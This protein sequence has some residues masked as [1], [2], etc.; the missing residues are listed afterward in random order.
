MYPFAD[1]TILYGRVN[2]KKM[3]FLGIMEHRFVTES[4]K[5]RTYKRALLQDLENNHVFEYGAE[6]LLR[7]DLQDLGYS[8]I[9]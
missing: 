1:N 4:G 8:G 6:A 5:E 2:Q 9:L 7:C 3:R